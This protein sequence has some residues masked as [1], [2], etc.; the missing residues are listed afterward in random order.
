MSLKGGYSGQGKDIERMET[1]EALKLTLDFTPRDLKIR[2]P[3]KFNRD[4]SKLE[5][6]LA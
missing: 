5:L 6:F 2:L 3:N 1:P 4:R